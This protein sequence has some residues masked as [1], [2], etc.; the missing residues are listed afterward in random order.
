[1]P[2][3]HPP[4]FGVIAL[5]Y[6][7]PYSIGFSSII[8]AEL[9]KL[10]RIELIESKTI[11]TP[12]L[13]SV[14]AFVYGSSDPIV[15]PLVKK[16][17]ITIKKR[18][19]NVGRL[20]ASVCRVAEELKRFLKWILTSYGAREVLS[21]ASC[22]RIDSAKANEILKAKL[23]SMECRQNQV[24]ISVDKYAQHDTET[25]DSDE[26]DNGLDT[27]TILFVTGNCFGILLLV[28]GVMLMR[29]LLN[30]LAEIHN[31]VWM[32][33][34]LDLIPPESERLESF[35]TLISQVSSR[36]SSSQV[37]LNRSYQRRSIPTPSSNA[38]DV[39]TIS[40]IYK[41]ISVTLYATRIPLTTALDYATRKTLIGLRK[42][43][44]NNI[45]RFYGLANIGNKDIR[46]LFDKIENEELI[47]APEDD[48]SE[49]RDFALAKTEILNYYTVREQC[50]GESIFF[51][52]HCSSMN[53]PRE[54]K[55]P[56]TVQLIDAVEY[57]HGH[58]IV[59]GKL[60]SQCCYFDH[61]FN[62]KV[63]DWERSEILEKYL[64]LH[65]TDVYLPSKFTAFLQKISVLRPNSERKNRILQC[66]NMNGVMRLRWRPPECLSFEVPLVKK[67]F[68]HPQNSTN[69]GNIR[70]DVAEEREKDVEPNV[71]EILLSHFQDSTV[72][73]YSLGV[74]INEVWLR[75]I[76]YSELDPEYR[77][78]FQLLD[79][80]ARGDLKLEISSNIP[81]IVR[82]IITDC[83]SLVPLNRP[84]IWSVKKQ[85]TGLADTSQTGLDVCLDTM[86][87]K[88]KDAE[89]RV[90]SLD[91][92]ER[93]LNAVQEAIFREF[94][95]KPLAERALLSTSYA[96]DEKATL[97]HCLPP[98]RHP[99]VTV[100]ALRLLNFYESTQTLP[101][102]EIFSALNRLNRLMT[103]IVEEWKVLRISSF[104]TVMMMAGDP[105][106]EDSDTAKQAIS[107]ADCALD[108]HNCLRCFGKVP[109]TEVEPEFAIALDTGAVA[110]VLRPGN[111]PALC[112]FGKVMQNARD[113][114][115]FAGS[116]HVCVSGAT[117]EL[118]ETSGRF[119]ME[120]IYSDVNFEAFL[121]SKPIF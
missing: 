76:P 66:P 49:N 91:E 47:F 7:I 62:I 22:V 56:V 111:A 92:E 59:H 75:A 15:Y 71:S 4:L 119:K 35:T 26:D 32:I 17:S 116:K 64:R 113:L 8:Q 41:S 110:I 117:K 2:C 73:I 87:K 98:S 106:G 81:T 70:N 114:L 1:M 107:V 100:C 40:G 10:I 51:F 88:M 36:Q 101:L 89:R 52:M 6:A 82:G 54:A 74:I 120:S 77:D 30:Q 12:T 18:W 24:F 102:D 96:F 20:T 99:Q 86:D 90:A 94:L 85:I 34:E 58:G 108:L 13:P 84:N 53:F 42:I 21:N 83:I 78:E 115:K 67:L 65:S 93:C 33:K 80:I 55:I 11:L 104:G 5:C 97:E 103:A 23:S 57:L 118:L 38:V 63:S 61:N 25:Q 121:M 27:L 46:T 109:R 95:P 16:V 79:A 44:H 112:V 43:S 39:Q 60:N 48:F 69:D 105:L 28:F 72:D 31:D 29:R 14:E 19:S 37:D 68:S 50:T 3:L 9:Y 45:L